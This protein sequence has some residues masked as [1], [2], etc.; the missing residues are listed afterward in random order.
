MNNMNFDEYGE[1]VNGE[2]TY[3]SIANSLKNNK[4][5]LIGWCH[6]GLHYDIHFT[7][8]NTE[9]YGIIQRGIK[10]NYLFVG[11]VGKSFFGFRT[12]CIKSEKYICEKLE[13]HSFAVISGITDLINGIITELNE[14][15]KG[16]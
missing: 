4:S 11:I 9:K 15:E 14:L 13:I 6:N 3:K 7:L 16:K 10:S 1:I 12:D 5:V 2:N 8:G